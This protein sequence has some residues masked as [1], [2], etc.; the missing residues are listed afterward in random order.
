[1]LDRRG[2]HARRHER[3]PI[4]PRDE[5]RRARLGKLGGVGEGKDHRSPRVGSHLAYDPLREGPMDRRGTHH[6]GGMYCGH[7]GLQASELGRVGKLRPLACEGTLLGGEIV[8]VVEEESLP[9]DE[10][11]A[12]SR[13]LAVHALVDELL[14]YALG[15]AAAGGSG[16]KAQVGLVEQALP[17][18]VEATED[19][20]ERDDARALDVVVEDGVGLCVLVQERGGMPSPKVLEVQV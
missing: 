1:M 16:A 15:D 8:H 14:E 11:E 3:P 20:R 7:D 9:V 13:L 4:R 6:D 2:G 18:D 19:A 17:R 12:P 5:V 10:V